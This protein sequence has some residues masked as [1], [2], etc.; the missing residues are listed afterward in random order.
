MSMGYLFEF[1]EALQF[2][3]LLMELS[4]NDPI[5]WLPDWLHFYSEEWNFFDQWKEWNRDGPK[6]L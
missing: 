4:S 2:I 6:K 1:I 5:E 3:F